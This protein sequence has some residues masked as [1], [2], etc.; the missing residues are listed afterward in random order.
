V[1]RRLRPATLIELLTIVAIIAVAVAIVIPAAKSAGSANFLLRVRLEDQGQPVQ[2]ALT[3]HT[4]FEQ[5][6]EPERVEEPFWRGEVQPH[7]EE[8]AISVIYDIYGR[9]T[10]TGWKYTRRYRDTVLVEYAL[11]DGTKRYLGL[12]FELPKRGEV[13]DIIVPAEPPE[14]SI[15]K[16][17]QAFP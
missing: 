8:H 3:H 12:Q 5:R 9:A 11:P 6:I 13:V 15:I 14:Q 17:A 10:L 16:P 1:W 2:W 4:L 7:D